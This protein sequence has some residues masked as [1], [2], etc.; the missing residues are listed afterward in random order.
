[1]KKLLSSLSKPTVF[2]ILL[3]CCAIAKAQL[4]LPSLFSNNMVLQQNDSVLL[5]GWAQPFEKIAIKTSWNNGT[6]TA[7]TNNYAQWK[8]KIKTPNAGGPYSIIFQ[9]YSTLT[10]ENVMIGEVWICSGQSNMEW[11]YF[12]GV[13]DLQ[14][15]LNLHTQN[16]IRFF[17][18][19]KSTS[20]FP[21][22]DLKAQWNVCDSFILKTFSAT[23]YFFG[24]ALHNKLNVPI[25]IINTS[26][27]ATPAEVWTPTHII[28]NDS[29]L[30]Q[31]SKKQAD[32][33]WCPSEPGI[34]YNAMIH[35]LTDFPIAGVIWY[36]GESNT[37]APATYSRL[38]IA[39]VDE[40]RKQW[41]KNFPFYLVQIAPYTYGNNYSAALI[42]EQQAA[43]AKHINMGMVVITDLVD[44]TTNIHPRNKK[45]VGNRLASLAAFGHYKQQPVFSTPAFEKQ[46]IIKDKISISFNS[47]VV[48]VKIKGKEP[49]AL[50]IA[51]ED[52]IFHPAKAKWQNGKLLVWSDVVKNPVAVRYSFCNACIG[53]LFS[54][55]GLPVGSFRTDNWQVQ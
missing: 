44:D 47:D 51:G 4:R 46:E 42:R 36:Q 31:A 20:A 50:L 9:G 39:M 7:V 29:L 45:D 5:W 16:N 1:M 12:S 22:N 17:A 27:G 40:W 18:V 43:A 49:Q 52:K 55:T 3:L 10:L 41:K 35:P 32:R 37:V 25:G 53:N 19:P 33:P 11:N 2:V 13:A 24:K 8:L 48:D 28:Q 23:G 54:Q 34:I 26:W 6:D 15:E 30:L 14:P 21:L 38:L